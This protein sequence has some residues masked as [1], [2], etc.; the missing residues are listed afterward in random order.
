MIWSIGALVEIC[1][2]GAFPAR[3]QRLLSHAGRNVLRRTSLHAVHREDRLVLH[4]ERM[5]VEH[6]QQ[7]AP[8]CACRYDE[9]NSRVGSKGSCL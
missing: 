1:P 5:R 2:E 4:A 9:V 7:Q 6:G 3:A 8:A